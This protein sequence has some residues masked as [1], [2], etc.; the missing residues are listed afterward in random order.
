MQQVLK[1]QGVIQFLADLQDPQ[2][3][4][5]LLAH[6]VNAGRLNYLARTTPAPFCVCQT[7]LA[8]GWQLWFMRLMFAKTRVS[9]RSAPV[10]SSGMSRRVGS[11]GGGCKKTNPLVLITFSKASF[12]TL[13]CE[14][15]RSRDWVRGSGIAAHFQVPSLQHQSEP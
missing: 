7:I 13:A 4:H 14:R 11:F 9:R 2:V 12:P 8:F 15:L 10:C 5:Y 3:T 6:S 1:Q